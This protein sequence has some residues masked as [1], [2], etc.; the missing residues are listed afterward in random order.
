MS[1]ADLFTVGDLKGTYMRDTRGPIPQDVPRTI[2]VVPTNRPERIEA[3]LKAW[4]PI[5]QD[6]GQPQVY[7]IEDAP[8]RST[9]ND[10]LRRIYQKTCLYSHLDIDCDLEEMGI[11]IDRFSPG[12]RSYGIWKAAKVK[13]DMIWTTDDDCMPLNGQDPVSGH[14]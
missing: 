1:E 13:P 6:H 10:G 8:E 5:W 3:F 14:R 9:S 7:I 11:C 4:A 12:V 2:I